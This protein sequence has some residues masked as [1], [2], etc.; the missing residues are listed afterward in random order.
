MLVCKAMTGLSLTPILRC[1]LL[2][3]LL[4]FQLHSS[5]W[6]SVHSTCASVSKFLAW[7]LFL[8]RLE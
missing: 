5:P 7:W 3:C 6:P 1:Y 4:V 8:G 2:V